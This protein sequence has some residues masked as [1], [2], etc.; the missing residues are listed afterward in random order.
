LDEWNTLSVHSRG[1]RSTGYGVHSL[2]IIVAPTQNAS[3]AGTAQALA[4]PV[5]LAPQAATHGCRHLCAH[6]RGEQGGHL[7]RH[8][9]VA[10]THVQQARWSPRGPPHAQTKNTQAR[11]SE[12]LGHG[13]TT[14]CVP[15]TYT[16]A[17]ALAHTPSAAPACPRHRPPDCVQIG[18]RSCRH[19]SVES[20]NI[21][22]PAA[23]QRQATTH[24]DVKSA[25]LSCGTKKIHIELRPRTGRG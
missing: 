23:Q 22:P 24:T 14:Q 10:C 12:A 2:L 7:L 21:P 8:A 3:T 6:N 16:H 4:T 9:P 11:A 1:G 19:C 17:Q 25:S 15:H 5:A 18:G 13:H 20:T